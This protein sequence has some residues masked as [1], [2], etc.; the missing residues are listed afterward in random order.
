MLLRWP[1]L[2][3]SALVWVLAVEAQELD[4]AALSVVE[5][6]SQDEV[7]QGGVDRELDTQITVNQTIENVRE[8]DMWAAQ[9]AYDRGKR[10][11]ASA[12]YPEAESIL[13]EALKN[14]PENTVLK[15]KIERSLYL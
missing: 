12:L 2:V 3:G 4:Q 14:A 9:E 10:S 1:A 7:S 13:R 15:E 11:L 6:S 8:A 5:Q